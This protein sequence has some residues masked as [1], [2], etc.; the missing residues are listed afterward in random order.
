MR[1]IHGDDTAKHRTSPAVLREADAPGE[2]HHET[3]SSLV[4][5]VMDKLASAT[6]EQARKGKAIPWALVAALAVCVV[7]AVAW[8][9]VDAEAECSPLVVQYV[10]H[11][12]QVGEE[13]AARLDAINEHAAAEAIRNLTNL[14]HQPADIQLCVLLESKRE[15]Q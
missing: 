7:G 5:R 6:V 13:E 11:Q 15:R 2:S 3:P 4:E 9:Y 10:L 8:R 1:E 12:A 14:E